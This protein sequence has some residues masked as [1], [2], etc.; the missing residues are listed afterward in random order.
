MTLFPLIVFSSLFIGLALF[1]LEAD[2]LCY[3][4]FSGVIHAL[5][6]YGV[7]SDINHKDKW[8]NKIKPMIN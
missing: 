5:F 3:V 2:T 6:S 7:V 4:G 1:L 8:G